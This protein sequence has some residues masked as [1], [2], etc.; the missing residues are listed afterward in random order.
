MRFKNYLKEQNVSDSQSKLDVMVR[1][2][3]TFKEKLIK[4]IQYDSNQIEQQLGRI[5]RGI[6]VTGE[7]QYHLDRIKELFESIKDKEDEIKM[8]K[9]DIEDEQ[10]EQ[11]E[12]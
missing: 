4:D 5:E 1:E 2:F 3:I 6:D 9:N 12:F 10:E 8:L 7:I 11:N